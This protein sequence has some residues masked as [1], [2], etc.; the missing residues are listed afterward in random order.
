MNYKL[1]SER[2][3][4]TL[5]NL[6]HIIRYNYSNTDFTTFSCIYNIDFSKFKDITIYTAQVYYKNDKPTLKLSEL[7]SKIVPK[8]TGVIIKSNNLISG[9]SYLPIIEDNKYIKPVINNDLIP[10]L[11]STVINNINNIYSELTDFC[12]D[13]CFEDNSNFEIE[14]NNTLIQK[15]IDNADLL[16]YMNILIN[17]KTEIK[18][19][20]SWIGY[21]V[22]KQATKEFDNIEII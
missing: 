7:K 9:D 21:A 12:D 2:K 19:E 4:L 13:I 8:Y 6:S 15:E 10:V 16:Q 18:K 11:N 22:L 14:N 20:D 3:K 17:T 1:S 5:F